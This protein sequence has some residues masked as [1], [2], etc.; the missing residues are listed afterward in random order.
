[1]KNEVLSL[2]LQGM[3]FVVIL[4]TAIIAL[5]ALIK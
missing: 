2:V 1:M 3:T 5:V 4:F